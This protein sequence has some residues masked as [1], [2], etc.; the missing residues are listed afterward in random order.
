MLVLIIGL[1]G[2]FMMMKNREPTRNGIT[3][4]MDQT[5]SLKKVSMDD[6]FDD[7]DYD[8]FDA[9]SRKDGPRAKPEAVS[10]ETN[11]TESEIIDSSEIPI[12]DI[13]IGS[14]EEEDESI[15]Q[16]TNLREDQDE[17]EEEKESSDGITM[18]VDEALSQED[19]EALF[20]E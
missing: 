8:P 9:Q 10:T 11:D 7:P 6:A 4:V 12:S 2:G 14:H 5:K 15:E 1:A 3:S 19:I 16:D 20:E 13:E 17:I 18:S